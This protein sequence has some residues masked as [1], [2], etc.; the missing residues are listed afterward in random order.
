VLP[1]DRLPFR[2]ADTQVGWV[3]PDFAHALALESGITID[4]AVTLQDATALPA[5]A[6]RMARQG[7]YAFRGEAFDVRGIEGGAVLST[8]DRGALPAFGVAAEGV[9]VNGLVTTPDGLMVWVAKRAANKLLDPGK[10]DHIVGGGVSAGMDARETLIKEAAEEAAIPA[11]LAARAVHRSEIS[12]A[13]DRAE[14]LRRDVL[15]CY[16]LELPADF[17]PQ[18]ADGEVESFALWPIERVF[19]EVRDTDN[20]KF[21][22]NLVLID[23][24][25]RLRIL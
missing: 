5:L 23:L 1:G 19:A 21:N 7:H 25:V 9:H 12:Y 3:T 18:A 15:Q 11:E 13:L 10:L 2:L 14:G 22:V 20:F 8:I 16:D 6:E 17:V 4:G 24:F